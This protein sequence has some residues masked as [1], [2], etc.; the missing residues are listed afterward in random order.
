MLQPNAGISETS[1]TTSLRPMGFTDILDTMFNLYRRNFRLFASICAVYFVFNFGLNLIF[2]ICTLQLRGSG[3]LGM[4]IAIV[5]IGT[6]ITLVATLFTVGGLIFAGAQTYLGKHI[7]AN[8]AFSQVKRRFWPYLGG[9]LLWLLVVGAPC[10]AIFICAIAIPIMG[11]ILVVIG[12]LVIATVGI[13]VVIYFGTRWFLWSLPV[14]VEEHSILNALRRSGEL[15][16]GSWWRVFGIILGI[17]LLVLII[18]SILQLSLLFVFGVTQATGGDGDLL[19]TLQRMFIPE[20]TTWADFVRYTVQNVINHLV[21][22]LMLPV[23]VIGSALLYFDL[24]IRKEGFDIEMRVTNEEA[25]RP[26]I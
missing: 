22:S 7:T 12:I 14:L 26:V 16:K 24:R 10:V 1:A 8:T 15:V 18:Q 17:L 4:M 3:G 25:E 5:V 20:L 9:N 2:G 11:P 19:T 23:G 6:L 21:A 13:P